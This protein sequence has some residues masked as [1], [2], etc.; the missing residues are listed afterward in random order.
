MSQQPPEWWSRRQGPRLGCADVTI[1]S[2]ASITAFVVLVLVLG[3]S[4][5]ILERLPGTNVNPTVGVGTTDAESNIL[6]TPRPAATVTIAP[7]A[8]P[9]PQPTN[10]PTVA[11]TATP[12]VKRVNVKQSCRLRSE[13]SA[14]GTQNI[15]KVLPPNTVVRQLGEQKLNEGV[16][17]FSVE[18]DDGSGLKGWMQEACFS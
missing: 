13:T 7:T 14:Q 10:T 6:V 1:V 9:P 11:P 3:R 16:T 2:I 4:D 17:W 8:T 15:L 12:T 18:L 5:F